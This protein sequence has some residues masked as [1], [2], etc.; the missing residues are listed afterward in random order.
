MSARAAETFFPLV[1]NT[2]AC[3]RV[4]KMA[5]GQDR[6]EAYRTYKE[7]E[8]QGA[9]RRI[10]RQGSVTGRGLAR[11]DRLEAYRTYKEIEPQRARRNT[12]RISARL[13][14]RSEVGTT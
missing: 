5:E 14:D 2:V 12:E 6:L 3:R 10:F 7:S 13:C 9:R 1:I 11:H 4:V 8:P